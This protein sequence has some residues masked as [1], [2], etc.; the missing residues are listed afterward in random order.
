MF[1]GVICFK[2]FD[3]REKDMSLFIPVDVFVCIMIDSLPASLKLKYVLYQTINDLKCLINDSYF[4]L[5]V[6]ET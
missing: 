1:E 4:H 6:S 3:N 5:G 2:T